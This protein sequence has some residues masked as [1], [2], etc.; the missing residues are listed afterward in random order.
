M[1]TR[2][3][4]PPTNTA[5]VEGAVMASEYSTAPVLLSTRDR[6]PPSSTGTPRGFR[7]RRLTAP[8]LLQAGFSHSRGAPVMGTHTS[9]SPSPSASR[10]LAPAGQAPVTLKAREK[11]ATAPT[12]GP[13]RFSNT[14]AR[15]RGAG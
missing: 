6:V 7:N 12:A 14:W 1:V 8:R 10:I 15:R 11:L 2:A 4:R 5:R 9:R 3:F 13:P